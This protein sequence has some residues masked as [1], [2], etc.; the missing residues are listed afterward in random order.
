MLVQKLTPFQG[1]RKKM[2]LF[3]TTYNGAY[4][5]IYMMDNS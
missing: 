5:V 2:R 3:Y 1:G 4:L